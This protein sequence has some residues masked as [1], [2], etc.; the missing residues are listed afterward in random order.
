MYA[1]AIVERATARELFAHPSHPYTR[2]L[3]ACL[4]RPGVVPPGAPLGTI[5]G[6]VPSLVGGVTGCAFRSRCTEARPGCE[7]AIPE[8]TRSPG[9]AY[10]CVIDTAAERA[11]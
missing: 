9:H 8:R 11:A 1:G 2:G 4:P 6:V 10:A 3:L 5:P 7:A